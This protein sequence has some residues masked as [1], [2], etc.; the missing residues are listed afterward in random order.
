MK[1]CLN[2]R[3]VETGT[4]KSR[5]RRAKTVLY[6]QLAEVCKEC[7]QN[8]KDPIL[9]DTERENFAS[10]NLLLYFGIKE[11]EDDEEEEEDEDEEEIAS[12]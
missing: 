6:L 10:C 12:S 8:F 5:T 3:G 2:E 1:R 7:I 11:E 9:I 4:E